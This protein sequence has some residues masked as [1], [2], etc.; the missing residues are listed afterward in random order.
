M[1]NKKNNENKK[2]NEKAFS[3]NEQDLVWFFLFGFDQF[4]KVFYP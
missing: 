4:G 3:H 2:A 1:R